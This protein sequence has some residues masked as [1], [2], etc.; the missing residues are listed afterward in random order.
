MTTERIISADSHVNPR[1]DL[2]TRC[3]PR[4]LIT[5]GNAAA[6]YHLD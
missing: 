4:S 5:S 1:K 6:L 2:W 3:A